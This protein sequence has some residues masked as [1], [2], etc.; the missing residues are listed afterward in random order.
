[1]YACMHVCIDP[2]TRAS[3]G[4]ELSGKIRSPK[5]LVSRGKQIKTREDTSCFQSWALLHD[6]EKSRR[7][8]ERDG[9]GQTTKKKSDG[10]GREGKEVRTEGGGRIGPDCKKRGKI[11][12]MK[13]S[14]QACCRISAFAAA[15]RPLQ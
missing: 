10:E 2:Q 5:L 13:E 9:E 4:T 15:F 6:T 7:K 11:A 14:G 8:R 12:R 1:M 3:P